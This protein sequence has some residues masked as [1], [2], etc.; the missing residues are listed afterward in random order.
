MKERIKKEDKS[1]TVT[2]WRPSRRAVARVIDPLPV[3]TVCPFCGS[4]VEL[5]KN[6]VIYGRE[7]GDWPWVYKCV[8]CDSHVGLHP[9][10]GIPLGTLAD[11]E[12]RLARQAAKAA[13]NPIWKSGEMSRTDAYNWLAKQLGVLVNHCHVGWFDVD[14]CKKVVQVCTARP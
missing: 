12:T 3:P 9:F 1:R 2:P 11:K 5:V 8:S 13:F 4:D 14:M 6:S 7:Y 10:T